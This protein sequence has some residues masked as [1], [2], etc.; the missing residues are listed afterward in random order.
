MML[1][2]RWLELVAQAEQAQ[3]QQ[4]PPPWL[5]L[6]I[7]VGPII[8]LFYLLI[9]RPERKRQQQR[10]EMLASLRKNARVVTAGGI[11]G[12]VT[13]VKDDEDEV[14]IRVDEKTGTRLRVTKSSIVWV[15]Q[16]QA[17]DEKKS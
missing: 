16:D 7:M 5:T 6:L 8:V 2:A 15:E 12:V 14:E 1:L 9:L 17:K 10:R 13:R 11:K 3:Q 4:P